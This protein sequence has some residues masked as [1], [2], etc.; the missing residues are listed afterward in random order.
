M[1][2]SIQ[3]PGQFRQRIP[4]AG[5][6]CFLLFPVPA[7]D[8]FLDGDRVLDIAKMIT[9]DQTN[10]TSGECIRLRI[11]STIMLKDPSADVIRKPRVV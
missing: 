3:T 11:E 5:D 9:E 1:T 10:R 2:G 4:P 7:L 8:L 6:N